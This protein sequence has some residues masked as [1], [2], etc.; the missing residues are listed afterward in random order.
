MSFGK[1]RYTQ[2]YEDFRAGKIDLE[3]LYAIQ[4]ACMAQAEAEDREA[5][6]ANELN[7]KRRKPFVSVS[8]NIPL[9]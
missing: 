9:E 6:L 7:R 1:D 4:D 8:L 3:T 5:K 2:A